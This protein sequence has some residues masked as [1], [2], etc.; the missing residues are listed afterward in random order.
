MSLSCL[1]C[2]R[3]GLCVLFLRKWIETIKWIMPSW[4][5]YINK[6]PFSRFFS[7][8]YM[9]PVNIPEASDLVSTGSSKLFCLIPNFQIDSSN[10][11]IIQ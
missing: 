8:L 9:G 2:V 3:K 5:I 6:L 7:L 4:F 10:C 1:C 11:K